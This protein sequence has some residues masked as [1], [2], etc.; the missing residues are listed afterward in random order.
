MAGLYR[1]VLHQ[2]ALHQVLSV[3]RAQQRHMGGMQARL[4]LCLLQPRRTPSLLLLYSCV[5][6]VQRLPL[7]LPLLVLLVS[8]VLHFAAPPRLGTRTGM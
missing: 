4:S 7:P 6:N 8:R 3:S 1:I 5:C 2:T